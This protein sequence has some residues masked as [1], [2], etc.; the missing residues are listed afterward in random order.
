MLLLL[1]KGRSEEELVAKV[2]KGT[3]WLEALIFLL[4]SYFIRRIAIGLDK[5]EELSKS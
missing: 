2:C 1:P 5:D 3:T 4:G